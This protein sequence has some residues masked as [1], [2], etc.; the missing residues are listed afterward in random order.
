MGMMYSGTIEFV[1]TIRNGDEVID[2]FKL[3]SK[4][5]PTKI[6]YENNTLYELHL[7]ELK[8]YLIEYNGST[9]NSK[10]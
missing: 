6:G 5:N 7:I 8:Q 9:G 10:N 4:V 2:K 1:V 3:G